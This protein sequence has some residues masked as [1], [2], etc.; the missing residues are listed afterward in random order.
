MQLV[1]LQLTQ[2]EPSV[3]GNVAGVMVMLKLPRLRTT[4]SEQFWQVLKTVG[5]QV[6]Q[7]VMLHRRTQ[8]EL[9]RA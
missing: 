6:R 4:A 9:R 1:T 7:L 3:L 2:A 8:D 5:W